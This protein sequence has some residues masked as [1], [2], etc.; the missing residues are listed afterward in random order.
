V[1]SRPAPDT[2]RAR[3]LPPDERR[4]MLIGA[5]RALVAQFGPKVTTKQIAE[6][7]GVAEGTIFRVF[8]DKEELVQAAIGQALDPSPVMAELLGVDTT[9]PLRERLIV[10]TE[11]M[12]RRLIQVFN[13]M[14]ALRVSGPP[15]KWAGRHR[16]QIPP[17]EVIAGEVA[18]LLE[19]DA[20]KF[21]CPVAEVARVLRLLTFA[22]SHPF[23][24]DGKIM[25][26]EEIAVVVL[27]GTLS[28]TGETNC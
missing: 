13:L 7:A 11:I 28:R 1:T 23:I 18:R 20:D 3:P 27:D 21:R 8:R 24:S 14:V 19:P 25:S 6:A 16:P 15:E 4:A 17:N 5:T 12:Q 26:A 22:G 10:V 2:G 9:L